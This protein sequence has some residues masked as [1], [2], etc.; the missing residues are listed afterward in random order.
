V[1]LFT[2]RC[3]NIGNNPTSDNDNNN[4]NTNTHE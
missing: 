3:P 4:N 2:T 1:S